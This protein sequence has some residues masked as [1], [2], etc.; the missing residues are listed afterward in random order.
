MGSNKDTLFQIVY[1][2]D[3]TKEGDL[4]ELNIFLGEAEGFR[5]LHM[6]ICSINKKYDEL[7]VMLSN[8]KNKAFDCI[9]LS[10]CH[11]GKDIRV[12]QYY[13]DGYNIHF[14]KLFTRKTDGIIVYIK[15]ELEQKTEELTLKD[16]NGLKISIKKQNKL[17]T[18]LAL[19]RSPKGNIPIFIQEL[20][21][22][23]NSNVRNVNL[24]KFVTGDININIMDR[25]DNLVNEYL[26]LMAINGYMSL[27]NK[28]TRVTRTS[29]SCLDHMFVGPNVTED[30]LTFIATTAISDHYSVIFY[31]KLGKKERK[32][33]RL[34]NAI[35]RNKYRKFCQRY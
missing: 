29:S 26:N 2:E 22:F 14:T 28:P 20:G 15:E 32:R 35:C 7:K 24:V 21:E 10:E 8:L 9:I 4:D 34:S 6:N 31:M 23:I 11:I 30:F 3:K 33:K 27:V 17:F 16:C 1:E 25:R 19:Y 5:M 18:G 12:E 13:L